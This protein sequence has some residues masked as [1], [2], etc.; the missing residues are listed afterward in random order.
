[1]AGIEQQIKLSTMGNYF[2]QTQTPR[3]T[4]AVVSVTDGKGLV[5]NYIHS[6]ANPGIYVNTTLSPVLNETYLLRIVWQ[7]ETYEAVERMVPVSPINAIYQ[8]FEPENQFEDGGIKVFIDFADPVSIPNYYFW[9]LLQN[10]K[11]AIF[12]DPGNAFNLISSDKFFDGKEV[13]GY[14][15]SEEKVFKPGDVATVRHIGISKNEFD[16]LFQLFEQ[17]GQ[18]GQLFDIP[19]AGVSGN[20]R[21]LNNPRKAALGYFGASEIDERTLTIEPN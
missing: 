15:P 2:A 12:N 7:G 10:G 19:A 9:E 11:N 5:H 1:V 21:N 6:S 20:I 3:V 18:T 4:D 13:I 8:R 16:F 14:L 17:T